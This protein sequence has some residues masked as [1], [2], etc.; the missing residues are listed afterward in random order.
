VFAELPVDEAYAPV[1]QALARSSALLLAALALA[2]LAAVLLARRM[3]VPIQ[4][5]RAGAARIGGGD[6]TQR[7]SITTRDELEALAHQFNRMAEQLEDS[8]AGLERKSVG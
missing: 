6:L 3:V 2:F 7:I 8:Y 5:I 1:Y 4:A